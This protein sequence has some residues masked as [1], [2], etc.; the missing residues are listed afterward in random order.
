ME[1]FRIRH[2]VHRPYALYAGRIDA[3]KGCD[4]MLAFFD[5]LPAGP[6][7]AAPISC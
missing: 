7:A 5:A 1:G 2:G 4:E 3:G 6:S